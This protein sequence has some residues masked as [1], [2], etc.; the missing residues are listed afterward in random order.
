LFPALLE[1]DAELGAHQA[2]VGPGE[3]ADQD[4]A[5]LVVDGVGPLDPALLHEH[6]LEPGTRGDGGDLA[7]VVRLH[8]ADRDE[9]VAALGERVGDEVF[10]FAGLVPA[11]RDAGVAVLPLGPDRGAAEVRGEPVEPVHRGRPEQQRVTLELNRHD[12]L[13]TLGLPASARSAR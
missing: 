9:G 2:H 6:A 13:Q 11:V 5:D 8:A 12:R 3:A 10:E 7:G 4:V 1:A